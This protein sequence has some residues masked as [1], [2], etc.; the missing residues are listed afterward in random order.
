M[1][2]IPELQALVNTIMD[3]VLALAALVA[4]QGELEQRFEFAWGH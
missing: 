1:Q 3:S 2:K 4:K